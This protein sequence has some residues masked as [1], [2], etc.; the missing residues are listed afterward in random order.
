MS[1]V[2]M[3]C[4]YLGRSIHCPSDCRVWLTVQGFAVIRLPED[5]AKTN[6]SRS[7]H[8]HWLEGPFQNPSQRP[9]RSW[10]AVHRAC[11]ASASRTPFAVEV[12]PCWKGGMRPMWLWSSDETAVA[13]LAWTCCRLRRVRNFEL[14]TARRSHLW[15]RLPCLPRCLSPAFGLN[16][17]CCLEQ[18][19]RRTPLARWP[20]SHREKTSARPCPHHPPGRPFMVLPDRAHNVP[21]RVLAL[22]VWVLAASW[23]VGQRCG[24]GQSSSTKHLRPHL[25]A[26]ARLHV[27]TRVQRDAAGVF[28]RL[29]R[30]GEAGMERMRRVGRA[31]SVGRR[32]CWRGESEG[33]ALDGGGCSLRRCERQEPG[34]G[35]A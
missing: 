27:Q 13:L 6:P 20:A 21:D 34:A 22:R 9:R 31:G 23:R 3:N 4:Y 16:R 24:V 25:K 15:M 5:C 26:R 17:A 1:P 19:P 29:A 7:G 14:L 11:S 28:A 12:S 2:W 10:V 35:N 18:L 33:M 30:D 8:G 32:V